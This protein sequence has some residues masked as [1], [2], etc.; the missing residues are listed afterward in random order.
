MKSFKDLREAKVK[1]KKIKG[2]MTSVKKKGSKY[3]AIIDGDRLDTF[4]SEKDAWTGISQF[5]KTFKK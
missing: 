5:M 4:N 1:G 3:D 2:I